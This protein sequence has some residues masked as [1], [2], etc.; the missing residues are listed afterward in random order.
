M[1]KRITRCLK[2][3]YYKGIIQMKVDEKLVME[4]ILENPQRLHWLG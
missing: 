1:Q 4:F 3:V 2:T